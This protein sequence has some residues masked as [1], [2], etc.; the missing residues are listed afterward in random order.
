MNAPSLG[1]DDFDLSDWALLV[2]IV[3]TVFGGLYAS[4]KAV[5]RP[6]LVVA[7]R[8]LSES[9]LQRELHDLDHASRAVQTLGRLQAEL[10]MQVAEI[11][12]KVERI[13]LIEQALEH[14]SKT[15]ERIEEG[16]STLQKQ[17][18]NLSGREGGR[19][20]YDPEG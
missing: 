17:I 19:R 3:T 1:P 6:L 5:L 16:V 11:E 18:V 10:I 13:P 9:S 20:K 4:W 12:P 7:H 14:N 2:G 15:L 8:K